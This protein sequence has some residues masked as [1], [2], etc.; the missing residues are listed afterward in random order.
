MN[1]RQLAVT[2]LFATTLTSA[3]TPQRIVSTT[4]SIT[5]ILFAIGA[6]DRVAGVTNY[7]HY[8]AAA[9]KLPK[10]GT[11]YQPN[12]EIILSLKPEL[13]I[14]QRNTVGLTEKI[15]ALGLNVLVVDS[16]KS[17]GVEAAIESIGAATGQTTQAAALLKQIRSGLN[18]LRQATAKR[19][20]RSMMFIAGRTQGTLQDIVVAGKGSYL[21]E[22]ITIAGGVNIFAD[23]RTSYPKITFEQVLA[24]NPDV[25]VDMADMSQTGADAKQIERAAIA[26]WKTQSG[27]KAVRQNRVF[28]ISNDIFVVPGPRIVEA[29]K[30]FAAMLH[31]EAKF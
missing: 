29:A 22:L 2:L 5:E 9:T 14:V 25:V 18:Q 31:P 7:C 28:S 13:V 16:E 21:D 11:Y 1:L 10:I 15:R 20:P 12:I 26:L 4:P 8:P 6:G 24:R 27:L 30:A 3:A 19:S 23:S 17:A